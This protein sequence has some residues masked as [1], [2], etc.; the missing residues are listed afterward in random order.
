MRSRKRYSPRAD[1]NSVKRSISLL[2]THSILRKLC[3]KQ[4]G[5]PSCAEMPQRRLSARIARSRKCSRIKMDTQIRR[6]WAERY[7][8]ASF[9][10]RNSGTGLNAKGFCHMPKRQQGIYHVHVRSAPA[11]ALTEPTPRPLPS[12]FLRPGRCSSDSQRESAAG[13]TTVARV[14]CGPECRRQTSGDT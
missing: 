1:Q 11:M 14:R 8:P 3:V 9:L 5:S 4:G 2:P 12:T 7:W 10:R 13:A 6:R